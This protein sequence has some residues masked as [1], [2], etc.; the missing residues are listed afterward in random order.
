MLSAAQCLDETVHFRESGQLSGGLTSL[1]SGLKGR[2]DA[3]VTHCPLLRYR[4]SRDRTGGD[5][6]QGTL[7]L[8]NISATKRQHSSLHSV[9]NVSH[10][11]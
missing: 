7:V 8:A 2:I 9:N 11:F 1:F 6:L 10:F 3:G 5:Q 4:V